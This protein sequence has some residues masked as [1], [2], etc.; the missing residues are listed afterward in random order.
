MV[1]S[2]LVTEMG[3]VSGV[4]SGILFSDESDAVF[5]DR[6]E[7]KPPSDLLPRMLSRELSELALVGTPSVCRDCDFDLSFL[8]FDPFITL[9]CS[10]R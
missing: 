9:Q 10:V 7:R 5:F 2:P 8:G 1:T 3:V 4:S 6:G